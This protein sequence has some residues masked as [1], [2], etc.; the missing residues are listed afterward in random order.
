MYDELEGGERR[1]RE[2]KGREEERKGKK[3]RE[4]GVVYRQSG[5]KGENLVFFAGWPGGPGA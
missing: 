4:S 2:G 1:K 5:K 3:K